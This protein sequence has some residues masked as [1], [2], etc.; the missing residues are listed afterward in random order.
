[1]DWPD[2]KKGAGNPRA[3]F[4]QEQA[5]L[6]RDRHELGGVSIKQLQEETGAGYT[7][8]RRIVKGERYSEEP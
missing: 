7:T 3:R 8:I 6:L 1:M 5:E 2:Q 4:T